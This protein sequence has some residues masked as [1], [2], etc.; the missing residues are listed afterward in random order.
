MKLGPGDPARLGAL[1]DAGGVSFSVRSRLADRVELCLFD[2]AGA[3]TRIPMPERDGDIW[4][5]HVPGLGEGARYGYRAHGPWAPAEG[6]RFNPAKLLLDP[7]S[8]ALSAPVI[9]EGDTVLGF[10]PAAPDAPNEADSA[11]FLPRSIVAAEPAPLPQGPRRPWSETVIY[12]AHLKGLTK[13]LPGLPPEIAGTW[14]ALAHPLVIERLTDLGVT[15]LELLPVAAFVDLPFVRAR[16]LTNYWGYDPIAPLAPEPRYLGPSGLAGVQAAASALHA[17]GIELILDVVFNHT[18]EGNGAGPT[19]AFRGLDDRDWY[20]PDAADPGG[21]ANDAGC[22]N[23]LDLSRPWG[24]RLALDALRRWAA[25]GADGF[26]FDLA[27]TLGRAPD[28]FSPEAPFF[29]ALAADPVLS[30]LK[31]IAE[32]WDLGPHG[33]RP[34]GFPAPWG[35]WNDHFRDAARGFWRGDRRAAHGL[36]GRLLGSADLYD[37]P[38]R[39]PFA[40]VN[41][42]TAHDGFTLRDLT[43]YSRKRNEANGEENRDGTDHNLSDPCGPEGET[44]DPSLTERR[45]RRRRCLLATL[46]LAQGAPMLLAG[47]EIGR[48]QEGNNNTW[49]QD[50]PLSWLDWAG[51]DEEMR[52]FARRLIAFRRA[53]P[54]LRQGL[55]LHAERRADGRPDVEW[56]AFEGGAPDWDDTHLGRFALIVRGAAGAPDW[57]DPGEEVLIAV[58]RAAAAAL[59]LPEGEWTRG[60]DAA[61]P[62]APEGPAAGRAALA[63]HTIAAFWRPVPRAGAA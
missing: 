51:A 32:P 30:R 44:D 15:A 39:R 42:V 22:G 41:F 43:T 3:E 62:E 37:R 59:L 17:A 50:G 33:W 34:G 11:P 10:D 61:A 52:A 49:C 35:E 36:A 31:L 60:I 48:T 56:R 4:H 13:R 45:A 63:A 21:Y 46:L 24:V 25:L 23:T 20:R 16:G 57:A 9:C 7:W 29:A 40:S 53:H 26:R 18:G 38:G 28:D 8:R 58:N 47:D 1:P 5:V 54:A 12:E 14:D 19:L 2:E 27:V 6:L 55:H